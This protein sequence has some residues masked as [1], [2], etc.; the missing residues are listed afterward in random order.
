MREPRPADIHLPPTVSVDLSH[1]VA[2]AVEAAAVMTEHADESE[3]A[4]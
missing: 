4:A 3:R 2:A 1:L